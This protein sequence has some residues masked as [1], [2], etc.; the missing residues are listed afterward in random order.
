VG[1]WRTKATIGG[2]QLLRDVSSASKKITDFVIDLFLEKEGGISLSSSIAE[3]KEV[4]KTRAEKAFK[5]AESATGTPPSAPLVYYIFS[6]PPSS[7]LPPGIHVNRDDSWTYS[8]M[9]PTPKG[10]HSLCATYGEES[11]SKFV[12]KL[13]NIVWKS[14]NMKIVC[15]WEDK[16]VRQVVEGDDDGAGG[17]DDSVTGGDAM[18]TD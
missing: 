18:E 3:V 7:T 16:V 5:V 4:A 11:G 6:I 9:T 14:L 1:I 8:K 10:H 12:E 2:R 15:N 13:R 17:G